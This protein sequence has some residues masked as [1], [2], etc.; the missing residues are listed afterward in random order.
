MERDVFRRLVSV[1]R[2][3]GRRRASGRFRFTDATI[4]EVYLWS[5]LCGKPVSW[6]CVRDNWPRGLRRG[7]LPSQ[8]VVSRRLR[9]ASVQR[10]L[11]RLLDLCVARARSRHHAACAVG[12]IDGKAITIP[13]HSADTHARKGR[14]VG[15][16]ALGYKLHVIVDDRGE[17]IAMRIAALNVDE[18]EMARRMLVSLPRAMTTLLADTFYDSRR[19]HVTCAAAGVQLLAPRRVKGGAIKKRRASPTRVIA[20]EALETDRHPQLRALFARRWVIERFFAQLT[21]VT[22]GLQPP[23]WVRRYPT[24]R[25]W[26]HAKV[27][28]F[29][30]AKCLRKQHRDQPLAA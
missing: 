21:T 4:L 3:F 10:L 13:L 25:R 26:L 22:G 1:L 9:G 30:A 2:E 16:I 11:I 6:A 7:P 18:R 17:L 12:V 24:T 8:S 20:I 14:G 27:A 5:V 28:I 15:H 23:C 29:H 19:L